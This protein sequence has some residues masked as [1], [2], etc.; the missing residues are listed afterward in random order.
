MYATYNSFFKFIVQHL[1]RNQKVER[2]RAL[3][4][5]KDYPSFGLDI[6]LITGGVDEWILSDSP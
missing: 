6:S 5:F 1:W 4:T 2:E 3:R